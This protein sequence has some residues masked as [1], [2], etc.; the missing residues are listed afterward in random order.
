MTEGGPETRS[1]RARESE[2]VD[3]VFE[4]LYAA[5]THGA[6]AE[7]AEGTTDVWVH[8]QRNKARERVTAALRAL[9]K[10]LPR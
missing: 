5:E 1:K 7:R 8:E 4:L 10:V 9:W 3:R 6:L 2:Y